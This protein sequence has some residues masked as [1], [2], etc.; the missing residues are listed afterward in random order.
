M[1]GW[2]L[3][4]VIALLGVGDQPLRPQQRRERDTIS[5]LQLNGRIPLRGKVSRV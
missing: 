1:S 3:V 5:T 2:G 4:L